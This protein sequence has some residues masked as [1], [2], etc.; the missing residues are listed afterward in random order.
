[1]S[2][3]TTSALSLNTA[4]VLIAALE[5]LFTLCTNSG[6]SICKEKYSMLMT[7]QVKHLILNLNL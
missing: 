7:D 4:R 5:F 6:D 2:L 1:M 3:S